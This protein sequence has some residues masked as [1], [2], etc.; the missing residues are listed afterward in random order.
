MVVAFGRCGSGTLPCEQCCSS[1][2]TWIASILHAL[3][4]WCVNNVHVDGDRAGTVQSEGHCVSSA[5][6]P[7][8]ELLS[9]C[10]NCDGGGSHPQGALLQ[11]GDVTQVMGCER[12][13]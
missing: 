2:C 8:M 6:S 9:S 1:D 13:Q 12:D 11:S 10:N 5:G 4:L 7:M 3:L